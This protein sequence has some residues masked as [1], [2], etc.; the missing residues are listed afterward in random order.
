MIKATVDVT[1]GPAPLDVKVYYAETLDNVRIDFRLIYL[2]PKT[3]QPDF[4]PVL[5]KSTTKV[6][7]S[8]GS[9]SKMTYE[10]AFEYPLNRW[11]GFFIQFTFQGLENSLLQVSTETN[12]IPDLYPFEDCYKEGCYGKLV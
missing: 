1:R 3:Q 8:G 6:L 7:K 12:V 4:H 2:N 10:A 5:W 9:K 11:L